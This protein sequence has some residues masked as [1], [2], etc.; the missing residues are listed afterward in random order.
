MIVARLP[1]CY[2]IITLFTLSTSVYALDFQEVEKQLD[3]RGNVIG[4]VNKA[5]TPDKFFLAQPAKARYLNSFQKESIAVSASDSFLS[6]YGA[7]LGIKTVSSELNPVSVVEDQYGIHI[8]YQQKYNGA[9]VDGGEIVSHT[10]HLGEVRSV[11]GIFKK[12]INVSVNYKINLKR[13]SRI[14]TRDIENAYGRKKL[15]AFSKR[16]ARKVCRNSGAKRSNSN[17]ILCVNLQV[18][19]ILKLKE[20]K[21]LSESEKLMVK[22]DRLVWKLTVVNGSGEIGYDSFVDANSGQIIEKVSREKHLT[23]K[24]Y[25]CAD[26]VGDLSCYLNYSTSYGGVPHTHGRAEGEPARGPIPNGIFANYPGSNDVDQLY[27]K[28]SQIHAFYEIKFGRNGGN[29]QGGNGGNGFPAHET[30]YTAHSNLGSN[31]ENCINGPRAWVAVN[32]TIRL[33][34]DYLF[35]DALGH[36]YAHLV[37]GTMGGTNYGYNFSET[38]FGESGALNESFSD[39]M[40]QSYEKFI[41]SSNDWLQGSEQRGVIR[42]LS[43]P[44]SQYSNS[45]SLYYPDRFYS[46]NFY[47]GSLNSGG[48]H[49]NSTVPTYAAYLASV[50]A[51]FNGCEIQGIGLEK[52]EQIWYHAVNVYFISS[53][54]FNMA[55]NSINQACADLKNT[56]TPQMVAAGLSVTQSDCDQVKAAMQAVELNQGGACSGIPRETPLCAIPQY[57]ADFNNDGNTD[58]LDYQILRGRWDYPNQGFALLS[59]PPSADANGDGRVD[60]ADYD[61][62]L[63]AFSI[64]N[65]SLIP[66]PAPTMAGDM[67]FDSIIDTDDYIEWKQANGQTGPGLWADADVNGVIDNEDLQMWASHFPNGLAA[68]FNQDFVVDLYDYNILRQQW[69][70]TGTLSADINS[71]GV[72]NAFDYE[73]WYYVY[74][75]A[76]A[77][78][79]PTIPGDY[80]LDGDV[81]QDDYQAWRNAFGTSGPGLPA[82][83][84][85]DGSV[86]A[87]DYSVWRDNYGVGN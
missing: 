67:N 23:R 47:C 71:D 73:V 39:V 15:K 61:I 2:L 64:E 9:V 51:T 13:A 81:D 53:E 86:D 82:D 19:R 42:N 35:D 24:V 31:G 4:L 55:Y 14:A 28:A 7:I 54:T 17:L 10:N 8:R 27:D 84:N 16:E 18:K 5:A 12:D 32:G 40:G 74:N 43:N 77:P 72:V 26:P 41:S 79:A 85:V 65:P 56:P 38:N 62:W 29:G 48:I 11:N 70:K 59:I 49:H 20:F 36:E 80:D 83:G 44:T 34:K 78:L 3:S 63:S 66:P 1:F 50:G 87:A 22:Y 21:L 75:Q 46:A 30:R 33:C 45:I 76:G 25:D 57:S 69:N 37:F 68:D 6:Q 60:V 52:I 58:L